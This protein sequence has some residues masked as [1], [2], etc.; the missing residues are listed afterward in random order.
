MDLVSAIEIVMQELIKE[1]DETTTETKKKKIL[2]ELRKYCNLNNII[3][4]TD[5]HYLIK[6]DDDEDAGSYFPKCNP[7]VPLLKDEE[8]ETLLKIWSEVM[9][10]PVRYTCEEFHIQ[11]SADKSEENNMRFYG[12][13]KKHMTDEE[14]E[15]CLDMGTGSHWAREHKR[16][17]EKYFRGLSESEKKRYL[18]SPV[19]SDEIKKAIQNAK[20]PKVAWAIKRRRVFVEVDDEIVVY[21]EK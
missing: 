19:L 4:N 5:W 16:E 2:R 21:S 18:T 11:A 9:G 1:Y 10:Q 17:E 8:Y 6:C 3:N 14:I 12:V 20:S 13:Y 15:F 7:K